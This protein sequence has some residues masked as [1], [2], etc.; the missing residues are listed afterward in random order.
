MQA[1]TQ[2]GMRV[3]KGDLQTVSFKTQ[4]G[5]PELPD[6]PTDLSYSVDEQYQEY[7]FKW[8][9]PSFTGNTELTGYNL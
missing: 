8:Q 2:L 3:L 4:I 9:A 5:D 6:A 1:Y 7:T